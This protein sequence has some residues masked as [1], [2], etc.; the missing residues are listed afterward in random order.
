MIIHF[1]TCDPSKVKMLDCSTWFVTFIDD[2][3]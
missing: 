2:C 3:T 1:N